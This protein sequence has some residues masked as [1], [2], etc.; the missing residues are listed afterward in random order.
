MF[1]FPSLPVTHGS[2]VIPELTRFPSLPIPGISLA[3]SGTHPH[4]FPSSWLFPIQNFSKLS[5]E[6][7]WGREQG[8]DRVFREPGAIP[9]PQNLS[10]PWVRFPRIFLFP[11]DLSLLRCFSSP[12]WI[13]SVPRSL[14]SA[15]GTPRTPP[16][17][18][19]GSVGRGKGAAAPPAAGPASPGADPRLGLFSWKSSA[20]AVPGKSWGG[21]S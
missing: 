16:G 20:A 3:F 7:S 2:H 1:F 10:P 6:P 15:L 12:A 19:S 13:G 11:P 9:S 14:Q 21:T 4:P 8:W 18:F 17:T 5:P